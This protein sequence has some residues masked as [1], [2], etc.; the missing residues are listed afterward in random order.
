LT[1]SNVASIVSVM[2][3]GAVR[4]AAQLQERQPGEAV[5]PALPPLRELLPAGGLIRGS[6]VAV[7]QYGM[8]CLALIAG[9]SAAGAWCAAAGIPEF[10]VV[11]AAE[12]G[13]EPDRLLL[14]PDP[15]RRW[16]QVVA[17]LLEGCEIVI[18]RPEPAPPAPVRRRL[19][20]V[21]RRHAGVILAVGGWAG[22]P[23]RLKV[24]RQNWSGLGDGHGRLQACQAD[25]IAEGRGAAGRPRRQRLWLPAPDGAVA[26]AGEPLSAWPAISKRA[27]PAMSWLRSC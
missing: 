15:G 11:A 9:A 3:E 10:G 16:P 24:T 17:T 5:L 13:I 6:V 19:E 4:R 23:L 26:A 7:D 8:L 22:A 18:V 2:R 14:V 27:S 1:H 20:A 12:T 25:V 21:L